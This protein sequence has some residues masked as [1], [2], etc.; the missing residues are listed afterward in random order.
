M[1][2]HPH[3]AIKVNYIKVSYYL[4]HHHNIS[5]SSDFT[6]N[7]FC[8]DTPRRIASMLG[9]LGRIR[10]FYTSTLSSAAEPFGKMP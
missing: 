1:S 4:I 6:L 2:L 3:T 5:R 9:Q 8:I 10:S 7:M